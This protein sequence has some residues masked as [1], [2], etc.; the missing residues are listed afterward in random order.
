MSKAKAVSKVN[1]DS[2]IDMRINKSD[3]IELMMAEEEAKLELIAKQASERVE[4]LKKKCTASLV[5]DF[6]K[7]HAKF[8]ETI[9]LQYGVL[10]SSFQGNHITLLSGEGVYYGGFAVQIPIP[11]EMKDSI[12]EA[13]CQ[14]RVARSNLHEFERNN[15]KYK[16]ALTRRMLES[17]EEGKEILSKL[18]EVKI[19]VPALS[20]GE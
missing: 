9:E 13:E 6:K 2:T 14:S 19:S 18:K 3:I 11:K 16:T 15:K 10:G 17:S 7:E 8:I 12:A 1:V 20:K 4:E 5:D